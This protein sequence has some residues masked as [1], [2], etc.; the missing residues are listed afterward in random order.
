MCKTKDTLKKLVLTSNRFYTATWGYHFIMSFFSPLSAVVDCVW[1]SWGTW[2]SCSAS[3]G[4]GTQQRTR[5]VGQQPMN[6]GAACQGLPDLSQSCND[7]VCP[8]TT[9]KGHLCIFPFKY[10]PGF[11]TKTYHKCTKDGVF[12]NYPWCAT[13]VKS[14]GKMDEYDECKS[15]GTCEGV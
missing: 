12:T 8:C 7:H 15:D 6:G 13:K 2:G 4:G 10:R 5:T 9:L 11:S 14:D 1:N 3:C